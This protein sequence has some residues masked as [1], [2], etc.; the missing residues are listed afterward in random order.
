MS[1][2]WQELS[3]R[4]GEVSYEQLVETRDYI[5]SQSTIRPKIGVICGSG[6]GGLAEQ[7]DAEPAATVISYSNI[8]HFPAVSGKLRLKT[9]TPTVSVRM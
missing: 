2:M 9:P 8:P 1:G 3:H 4:G 6:L 5:L 7:L